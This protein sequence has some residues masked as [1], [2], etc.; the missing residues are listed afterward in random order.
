[1]RLPCANCG[2]PASKHPI[3]AWSKTL[4]PYTRCFTYIGLPD[5]PS[6]IREAKREDLEDRIR[7]FG[8][9]WEDR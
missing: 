3:V 9:D 2:G 5:D 8:S 6:T 7:E 1:M 4:G